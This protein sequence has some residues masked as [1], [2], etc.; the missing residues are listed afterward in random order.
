MKKEF[1]DFIFTNK[2]IYPI[3]YNKSNNILNLLNKMV[4]NQS[5]SI[6]K[7]TKNYLDIYNKN[8]SKSL[9]LIILKKKIGYRYLKIC[10]KNENVN[11]TFE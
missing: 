11:T 1:Y 4:K 6:R 8:I 3:L 5:F 9:V 2:P 7:L 10:L